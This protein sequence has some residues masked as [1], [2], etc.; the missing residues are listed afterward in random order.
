MNIDWRLVFLL[1]IIIHA[2]GHLFPGFLHTFDI[3]SMQ[4]IFGP[5]APSNESWLLSGQLK[6]DSSLTKMISVLFLLC[7]I[8]FMVVAGAFW[9]E[10]DWWK[11]LAV[12]LIVV[13]FGLFISWFTAFSI[14][15][16]IGSF[17]GNFVIIYGILNL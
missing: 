1:V 16:P 15:I 8:G 6:L 9:L 11:M 7:A 12:P 4:K 2:I 5:S 14:N 17:I 3:I 10:L 13:S